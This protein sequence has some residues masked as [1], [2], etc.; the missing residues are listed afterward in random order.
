MQVQ[1][2]AASRRG[3]LARGVPLTVACLAGADAG[4]LLVREPLRAPA[5]LLATQDWRGLAGLGFSE[6]LTAV[7]AAVLLVCG[8]WLVA[9]TLL[10]TLAVTLRA[11]LPRPAS[12]TRMRAVRTA[13][14]VAERLDRWSPL[15][16]RRLVAAALGVA[17]TAGA[18]PALA[19]DSPPVATRE[20][21][22]RLDGLVLPDRATGSGTVTAAPTTVHVRLPRAETDVGGPVDRP[23]V[24]VVAAGDSLWSIAEGL[25]PPD[26]SD[27]QVDRAWRLI[28]RANRPALGA[29]PDLIVPG[30]RLVIPAF[31]H[32]HHLDRKD[33]Q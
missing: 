22:G 31:H 1:A 6:L 8:A 25:L 17:V 2:R 15:L 24:V 14:W 9:V 11:V 5:A 21:A 30:D 23:D 26:A 7:M 12:T 29:D 19:V 27:Q 18:T 16:V 32:L 3:A 20:G 10:A 4:W 28:Y 13:G 33:P